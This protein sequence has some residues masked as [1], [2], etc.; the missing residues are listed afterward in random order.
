M[1]ALKTN[2]LRP[3]SIITA[4]YQ[5]IMLLLNILFFSAIQHAAV[6]LIINVGMFGFLVLTRYDFL[7]RLKP[8]S[9]L[10]VIPVNFTQ[11]HYLVHTVNPTDYDL[12]LL[13][14]D[15]II[16]GVHPTVWLETFTHPIITEILQIVY[17]TFYFLPIFLGVILFIRR[18]REHFNFFIFMVVLGF[19]VSYL[20][21]FIIPALGPRFTLDHLQT[22][23][24][25][26]IW[27]M[28]DIHFLL[29]K[30]ENIQRD[31]FPSGHTAITLLTLYYARRYNKSYYLLMIPVTVLMI[32]S[33]VYLRYHYVIDVLAGTLLFFG[34]IYLGPLLYKKLQIN[35]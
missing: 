23:S 34:L 32:I 29:N 12:L 31:A 10:V 15:Y 26:G 19:Y 35:T 1:P 3:L 11:L 4:G 9:L 18:D 30:L 21:Y 20:G 27:L 16:F 7:S 13:K 25:S 24:L 22:F 8:W 5:L 2:N 6:W 33:T 14:I 17:S 28:E